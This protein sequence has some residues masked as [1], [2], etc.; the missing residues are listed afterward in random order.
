CTP[1]FS[2]RIR[3]FSTGP[4]PRSSAWA[5]C[6][7]SA[8]TASPPGRRSMP[9]PT[10]WRSAPRST[11]P[12]SRR[13]CGPFP[14]CAT[15][16]S[17]PPPEGRASSSDRPMPAAAELSVPGKAFLAG[18]YSVLDR[19]QPAL[20]LAVDLRLHAKVRDLAGR[21]VELLRRPGGQWVRGEL[22]TEGVRWTS[23]VPGELRFAARAVEIAARL[24][25][26]EGRDPR[27][28]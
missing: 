8:R 3:R 27:G 26:E 5:P 7:A 18:E 17:A 15:R 10:W 4:R 9:A 13:R 16:W 6:G 19:G 21:A 20:V 2:R 23:G 14:A 28:F 22:T 12:R 1:T 11:P 24:C 25:A